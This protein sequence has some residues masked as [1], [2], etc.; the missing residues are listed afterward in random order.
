MA[1]NIEVVVLEDSD[2]ERLDRFLADQLPHYSREYLKRIIQEGGVTIEGKKL[3]P[4]SLVAEN[5]SICIVIPEIQ[6]LSLIAENIPVD[7]IY[8]DEDMLVVNKPSGMLTHPTGKE[9]TGTLVNA[10]LYHCKGR[11]S[12]INGIERPGIVHRLDRDTSGLLVIAKTDIAHRH[13]QSQIQARTLK[14]E[15]RAL[16]QG[17]FK[18]TSGTVRASI[19]RHSNNR[20]KM[21]VNHTGRS[22]TTHW[23]VI[24]PMGNKF[25]YVHCQLETGRT[26]QIRVHMAYIGHPLV[27]DVLY[28]TGFEKQHKPLQQGQLLQAYRITFQQPVTA[29]VITLELLPDEK[30]TTALQYLPTLL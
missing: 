22:A 7:I 12:H 29:K 5:N 21:A 26:H 6:P 20:D 1:T 15:Y 16:V 8:E 10:L 25:T 9:T 4:S 13:L 11:L 27:G 28:G 2:G 23:E 19:A 17:V 14:R 24:E 30:I 3:K 18:D